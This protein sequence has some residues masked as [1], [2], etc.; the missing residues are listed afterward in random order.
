MRGLRPER[1]I[2]RRDTDAIAMATAP[3]RR[4]DILYKEGGVRS[5][6]YLADG[7]AAYSPTAIYVVSLIYRQAS[8]LFEHAPI[9]ET[10]ALL[11]R[12]ILIYCYDVI[13]TVRREMTPILA[14]AR[15]RQF[16]TLMNAMI[17]A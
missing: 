15:K 1:R 10:W 4:R 11:R 16:D 13:R 8:M 3:Q 9:V 17:F 12:A 2:A 7:H 5:S 6:G 14:I